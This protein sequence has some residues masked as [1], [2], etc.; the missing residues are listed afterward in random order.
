MT[1]TYDKENIVKRE[2]VMIAGGIK[3][4][5]YRVRHP[6]SEDGWSDLQFHLTYM[7]HEEIGGRT[8]VSDGQVAV[9]ATVPEKVA[10]AFIR[11]VEESE[12]S[13]KHLDIGD[14][15]GSDDGATEFI[16]YKRSDGNIEFQIRYGDMVL[17]VMLKGMAKL[18]CTL[19]A[20]AMNPPVAPAALVE[21]PIPVE[22]SKP[23][24]AKKRRSPSN[25]TKKKSLKKPEVRKAKTK[26]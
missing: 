5:A 11:F 16:C 8:I 13:E 14:S 3:F 7:P 17:A 15:T 24:V 19:C 22:A 6:G 25:A 9:C 21:A 4:G 18:F 26:K 20:R 12:E 2:S 10:A 1:N 23:V